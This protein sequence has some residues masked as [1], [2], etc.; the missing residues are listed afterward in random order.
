[1]RRRTPKQESQKKPDED[2]EFQKKLLAGIEDDWLMARIR[3][4]AESTERLLD[5]AYLG[6]TSDGMSQTKADFVR[7]VQS[8][9]GPYAQGDHTSRQI[10]FSGDTAV[11][12]GV[13]T[14]KSADRESRFRYLRVYRKL[15]GE[16]RLIASQSTRIL[17]A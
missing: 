4:E 9:R 5:D 12:A 2:L 16:W 1:M 11:S 17:A 3:G 15:D 6:S 14:M 10:Q 7:S 13:V 8:S